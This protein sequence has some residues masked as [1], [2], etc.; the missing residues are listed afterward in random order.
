MRNVIQ[1]CGEWS[2]SCLLTGTGRLRLEQECL[3]HWGCGLF[4]QGS[5]LLLRPGPTAV[6]QGV[7]LAAF[8]VRQL[9]LDPSDLTLGIASTCLS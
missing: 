3:C 4:Y 1:S 9:E 8:R 7:A 2:F 5:R 6:A